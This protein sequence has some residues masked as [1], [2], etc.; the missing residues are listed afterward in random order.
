MLRPIW[1]AFR[2][3]LLTRTGLADARQDFSHACVVA[4]E[5]FDSLFDRSD[6]VLLAVS[7]HLGVHAVALTSEKEK[8][9]NQSAKG[10]RVRR[11]PTSSQTQQP[12]LVIE[13]TTLT[14]DLRVVR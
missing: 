3:L 5:F 13:L 6:E 2:L 4:F 10:R 9:N 8:K 1:F 11:Q 14:E 12:T 7:G